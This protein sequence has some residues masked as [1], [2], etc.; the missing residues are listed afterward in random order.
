LELARKAVEFKPEDGEY[1]NTL[2]VAQYRNGDFAAAITSLDK[3]LELGPGES[4]F[5]C[6]ALVLSMAHWQRGDQDEARRWYDQAMEWI[7]EHK[8]EDDDLPSFRA[9]AEELMQIPS[10]AET[11]P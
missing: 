2:G 6:N 10:G 5:A 3:S 1:W 8:P 9:E 7:K 11:T 4:T